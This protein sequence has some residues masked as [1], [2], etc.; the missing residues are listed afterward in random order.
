MLTRMVLISWPHDP[1]ASASQSAGITGVS[2]HTQPE[3]D[4]LNW[5]M[6]VLTYDRNPN[7][8]TMILLL[9]SKPHSFIWQ[10]PV[11]QLQCSRHHD[12]HCMTRKGDGSGHSSRGVC[13]LLGRCREEASRST[14]CLG[15]THPP[16]R[17]K[18]QQGRFFQCFFLKNH[19]LI[20]WFYNMLNVT[21]QEIS[22]SSFLKG[23]V[24]NNVVSSHHEY[25]R[26]HQ[27]EQ[28]L[29]DSRIILV[30]PIQSPS[31]KTLCR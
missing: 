11:A 27:S 14:A 16:G 19:T 23:T 7:L 1:P 5:H 24:V 28:L 10:M 21:Y 29:A 3:K 6:I 2:H 15:G 8:P 31:L 9:L 4:S 13:P 25:L 26:S 20:C 30:S 22:S 17:R 12:R 18:T